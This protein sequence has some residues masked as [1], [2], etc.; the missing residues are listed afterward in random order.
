VKAF[1]A[2]Y[3]S[4]NEINE[5]IKRLYHDCVKAFTGCSSNL[6][7]CFYKAKNCFFW[8]S[9]RDPKKPIKGKTS[10]FGIDLHN[11]DGFWQS[12]SHDEKS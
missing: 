5:N 6:N 11:S 8:T 3:G 7:Q 10:C 12:I 4:V 1:K 2:Y 9:C